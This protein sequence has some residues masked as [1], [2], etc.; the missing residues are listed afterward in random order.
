MKV[1]FKRVFLRTF[2]LLLFGAAVYYY[3]L[4][5]P[6]SADE[7]SSKIELPPGFKIEFFSK[8]VP[9]AR[10]MTR[11]DQ[12]TIFVGTRSKNK[13]YALQDLDGDMV[14]EKVTVVTDKLATPNGVAFRDGSLYVAQVNRIVRFDEIE[15]RI[16]NPPE[17]VVVNDSY[18]TDTHHGWKYISFGPD[19]YLY[20][21]VGAPCNICKESNPRYAS[22]T[23][24]KPDGSGVEIYAH[25]VR[26][27]VGFDW[28][29]ETKEL[30]FTDN[31]RDWLGDD[32]PPCELN[33]APKVGMN[34]G[35]PYCHGKDIKDPE[36]GSERSCSEF[37]PPAQELGPHVAP[38]G[39]RFYTG[40]MFPKDYA[41]QI[42]IA[43]HG[44]WNRTERIGYRVM[45]VRLQDSKAVSYEVFAR[46]WLDEDGNIRG[47]PVDVLQLP[48]G[49]LL[50]SDDYAGA[51]YRISYKQPKT[52]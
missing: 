52:G 8:S 45:L 48:D 2:L 30:W 29:P 12:G 49:S 46:G 1:S 35:F 20:V 28:H 15:Q 47:R 39:M 25:G 51:V 27:S 5:G 50:V 40:K 6:L 33:H 24:M 44:S 21:P 14:A 32:I 11:G 16:S 42:F 9:G 36:F 13:V 3:L 4:P 26:N 41:G 23:R 10:S 19:G 37:T 18:P 17:P 43:E 7:L 22:I 31:G 38:L 34:F